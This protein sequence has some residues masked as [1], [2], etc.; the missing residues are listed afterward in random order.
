VLDAVAELGIPVVYHA[1]RVVHFNMIAEEYPRIP[2]IVAHMGSH[3]NT[4]GDH[5]EAIN[6][7]RYFPNVY[8]DTSVVAFYKFLER[9]VKEA[10][11]AKLI[12]GSDGPEYDSRVELYKIKLLKLAPADEAKVLGGNIQRLLPKGTV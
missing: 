5:I 6:L 12:F 10:G 4:W 8:L 7:A 9:A 2:F 1:D 3:N 11:A